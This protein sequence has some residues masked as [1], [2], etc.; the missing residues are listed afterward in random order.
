MVKCCDNELFELDGPVV[1]IQVV[2]GSDGGSF[3]VSCVVW[4]NM[5]VM[6]EIAG[7]VETL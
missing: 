1:V 2:K 6:I 3:S 5:A 7:M 4:L